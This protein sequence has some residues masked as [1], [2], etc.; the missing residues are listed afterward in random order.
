VEPAAATS[1]KCPTRTTKNFV[2]KRKP[3]AD[4]LRQKQWELDLAMEAVNTVSRRCPRLRPVRAPPGQ[5]PGTTI[6]IDGLGVSHLRGGEL[7]LCVRVCVFLS[8][9][10]SLSLFLWIPGLNLYLQLM[11][12]G[13]QGDSRRRLAPIAQPIACLPMNLSVRWCMSGGG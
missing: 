4:G 13:R 1:S 11:I 7:S 9:T 10:L 8:H 6:T 3:S 12:D 5:V 2:A